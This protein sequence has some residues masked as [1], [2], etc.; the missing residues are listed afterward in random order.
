MR[1]RVGLTLLAFVGA[2]AFAPAPLPRPNRGGM[3]G[4]DAVEIAGYWQVEEH[5]GRPEVVL[6]ITPNRLKY[7]PDNPEAIEYVI[8]VNPSARPPTYDLRSTWKPGQDYLGIYRLDGDVLTLCYNAADRGRPTAFEGP[9][10]GACIE[11]FTRA[12]R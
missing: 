8:R 2:M 9:G 1:G 4:K 6:L 3:G 7:H 10:R 5:K 11:V 12:R